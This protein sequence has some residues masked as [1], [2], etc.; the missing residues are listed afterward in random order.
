MNVTSVGSN[1]SPSGVQTSQS[2]NSQIGQQQ[3]LQLLVAQLQYQNPMQP[4]DNQQFLAEMAQFQ[5]LSEMTSIEQSLKTM[6]QVAEVTE[7]SALLGKT[8]TVTDPGSNQPVTGIVRSVQ[9]QNGQA[10]LQIGNGTY[11]ISALTSI[12]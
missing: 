4:M 6:T 9:L 11:P 1:L 3:F 7:G 12:G 2:P 5:T 10:V 8:V